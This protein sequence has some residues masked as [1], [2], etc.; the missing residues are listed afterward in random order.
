MFKMQGQY[1]LLVHP[2]HVQERAFDREAPLQLLRR[3]DSDR[4]QLRTAEVRTDKGKFVN[5]AW[6]V[7]V[8]GSLWWVV[9]G[10]D[11][12]MKTV[13]RTSRFK[14]GLGQRIVR[15]GPLFDFVEQVNRTLMEEEVGQANRPW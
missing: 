8:D 15:G 11:K 5:T 7:E 6:E 14:R 9:I 13:I 2:R 1:D 3:F 4:W 12:T 10:F